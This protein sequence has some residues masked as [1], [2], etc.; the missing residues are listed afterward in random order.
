MTR[1]TVNRSQAIR[2]QL[3]GNV[4]RPS[5]EVREAL[6]KVGIVVDASLINNVRGKLR[7]GEMQPWPTSQLGLVTPS[8][9]PLHKHVAQTN[10]SA[11]PASSIMTVVRKTK[12]L[13]KEVGGMSSLRE[14][15]DALTEV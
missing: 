8:A 15:V 1:T 11:A 7:R 9:P 3:A 10:D 2:E 14:L 13:A 6:G 5:H 12:E 4:S